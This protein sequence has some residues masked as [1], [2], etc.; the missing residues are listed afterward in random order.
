MAQ[1]AAGGWETPTHNIGDDHGSGSSAK[2]TCATIVHHE[3]RIILES[4][5]RAA[6]WRFEPHA[7][8][9]MIK[10]DADYGSDQTQNTGNGR[11]GGGDGRRA[12]R[13]WP[14]DWE[15]SSCHVLLRKGSRSHPL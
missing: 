6:L 11:R 7:A 4:V 14:A 1:V 9:T 5:I 10:E 13:V 2:R 3:P 8:T 12:A 15:R